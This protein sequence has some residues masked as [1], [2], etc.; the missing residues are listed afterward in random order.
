LPFKEL[1]ISEKDK[2]QP[3]FNKADLFETNIFEG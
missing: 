3:T 2:I 1:I